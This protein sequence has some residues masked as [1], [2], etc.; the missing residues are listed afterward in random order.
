MKGL[1]TMKRLKKRHLFGASLLAGT[2]VILAKKIADSKKERPLENYLNL[3]DKRE[4]QDADKDID[5]VG[6][7][8]LD[9]IYR[10]DWQ[11]NGFPRS[12]KELEELEK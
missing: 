2:G 12:Q 11:A 3:L 4:S 6:L 9:S 10:A 8:Q 5:E 1:M 7:T